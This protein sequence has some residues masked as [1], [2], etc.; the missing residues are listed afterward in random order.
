MKIDIP[1]ELADKLR[2]MHRWLARV[3]FMRPSDDPNAAF[4]GNVLS[5]VIS[6]YDAQ[7]K[8]FQSQLGQL[9]KDKQVLNAGV[10]PCKA[11][12]TA[13]ACRANGCLETL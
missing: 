6:Q 2:M 5:E 7:F 12:P 10:L 8:A 11:C 13:T 4:Y 3:Q 9:P 1:D